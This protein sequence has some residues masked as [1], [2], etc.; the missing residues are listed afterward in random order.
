M[1]PQSCV[2]RCGLLNPKHGVET[3]DVNG[4]PEAARL[5]T[6]STLHGS[7]MKVETEPLWPW[8]S[9]SA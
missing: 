4:H 3:A 6:S 7:Q 1:G 8:R 5:H 2:A 9:L